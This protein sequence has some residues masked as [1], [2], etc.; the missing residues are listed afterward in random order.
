MPILMNLEVLA[1]RHSIPKNGLQ[2]LR[3][4]SSKDQICELGGT[5]LRRDVIEITV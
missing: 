5:L 1:R 3:N 2:D 4:R